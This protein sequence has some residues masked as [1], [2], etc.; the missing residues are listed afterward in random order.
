MSRSDDLDATADGYRNGRTT[1]NLST[2]T[3]P[4]ALPLA[5]DGRP[6][7]PTWSA[8]LGPVVQRLPPG[9]AG[10]AANVIRALLRV[11]ELAPRYLLAIPGEDWKYQRG[12]GGEAR[13][14]LLA[15][16]ATRAGWP[17]GC[18]APPPVVRLT[19]GQ[20]LDL[21]SDDDQLRWLDG[22]LGRD[23]I[24]GHCILPPPEPDAEPSP[25]LR[26]VKG[27]R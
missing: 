10:A 18:L 17:P 6:I 11:Y 4:E 16:L 20:A 19:E 25:S 7:P 23:R 26:V 24:T 27:G 8:L 15:D 9:E 5:P 22:G 14:N 1:P 12:I 21:L 3:E 13:A 2:D